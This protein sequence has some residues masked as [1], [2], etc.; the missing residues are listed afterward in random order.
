MKTIQVVLEKELL[1]EANKAAKRNKQNRSA[2]IRDALRHYLKRMQI[3]AAE[4][5]EIEAYSSH[6]QTPEELREIE[7]FA[8]EAPWPEP[9]SVAILGWSASLLLTRL[10]LSWC[11]L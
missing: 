5:R 1:L 10:A 9:Q 11:S 7:L 6:P 8:R 2:L 4:Q 3:R